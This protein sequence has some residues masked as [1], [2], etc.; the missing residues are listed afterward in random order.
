MSSSVF[1]I[2]QQLANDLSSIKV[3]QQADNILAPLVSALSQGHPLPPTI[4]PGLRKT[5][6]EG[7]LCRLFQPS[8]SS[9]DHF[10]VVV[11]DALKHT[12]LQQLHNHSGHLGSQK[13][14]EKLKK[15]YYWP[16]Y[17]KDVGIWIQ[18]CI[19]CHK[20][21]PPHLTQQG[22]LESITSNSPFEKLSWDIMGPLPLTSSGNKYIVVVINLFSNGSKP[23]L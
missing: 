8:S 6:K 4:A 21:N 13:T 9:A 3:A 1:A 17:E 5:F 2:S 10:Q 19:Q 22:P 23:F 16:G 7:V 11:L 18:E 12:V 15:R 14:L 20:R